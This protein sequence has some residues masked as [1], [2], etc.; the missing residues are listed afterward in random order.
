MEFPFLLAGVDI[1]EV[2]KFGEQLQTVFDESF[3][4]FADVAADLFGDFME[5][6]EFVPDHSD[7]I[8]HRFEIVFPVVADLFNLCRILF[9]KR[10]WNSLIHG[11]LITL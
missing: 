6:V 8:S 4:S 11:V 2:Q 9:T 5:V 3:G 10:K 7:E 1:G